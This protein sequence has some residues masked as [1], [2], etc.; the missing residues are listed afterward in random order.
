MSTILI[1]CFFI[2]NSLLSIGQTHNID[3]LRT[4]VYGETNDGKK[5]EALINLCEYHQSINKDSLYQYALSAKTLASKSGTVIT[6]SLA[7]IIFI[8]ALLRHGKTDSASALVEACLLEN[9]VSDPATRDIYFKLAA[10]KADC[11]GDASNYKDALSELYRI[12]SEAEQYKDSL[13][14]AKNISTVGVINY[15]LDHVPEAF[16]WYFKGLLFI[17][18]DSRFYSVAAVLYINLAETY[19]WVQQTDSATFYIDKA[20]SLC[21]KNEN[22]FFLANA[23]RVKA[24]IYK[25]KKEYSLAEETM[26]ECIAIRE[27]SEGKLLL[28][29]EQLAIANIYIRSGNIDKAIKI[30]NDALILSELKPDNSAPQANTGYEVDVLKIYYYN[31]L[32]Q[33]YRLKGDS[34][35]YEETL[36]KIIAA[37]D[38]FY[39]ANSA[40]SIAELQTKYEVQKKESTI[41]KQKLSITRKNYWLYGSILFA[42][43]LGIIGWLGFRNYRRKQRLGMQMALE[44][45]KRHATAAVKKAEESERVRIAADLHDNL[46]A[47]AACMA[48]NLNYFQPQ[49]MDKETNNA[50]NELKNNSYAIISQLNDTI[51]V[52][53]KDALSLTAISDRIKVFITRIQK[54]YPGIQLEV[55]EQ[56]ETDHHLFSSQAFHLYRILQEAVTN[57]LKHSNGKNITV[58]ITSADSWK[59]QI[60]D[61]GIGMSDDDNRV[62]GVNGLKNMKERSEE[63]G[64]NISWQKGEEGGTVVEIL[65]TT[66]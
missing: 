23:L 6:K 47:Y 42:V 25:E 36:E 21:K 28:S 51:W 52:L 54:S 26:L 20:I 30:L 43:M 5:L 40:R 59:V 24:S 17:T 57:S 62:Y 32:A 60:I 31:S 41:I 61:D 12:I 39:Q 18:D 66:I 9:P 33:C 14:L 50:Y 45:E 16:N 48:S 65:S 8:N 3:S 49:N 7:E 2:L 56:I 58:K 4:K 63:S 29:N 46:G 53:K 13:V 35:K 38:A 34:K 10:L 22:L 15:N 11:F 27:K 19:R 55:E 44:E 37:K 64:W 1:F